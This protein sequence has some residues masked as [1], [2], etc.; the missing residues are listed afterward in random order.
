MVRWYVDLGSTVII[1]FFSNLETYSNRPIWWHY[2]CITVPHKL[3][4]PNSAF[5]LI[6]GGSNNN[7]YEDKY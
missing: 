5:M 1:D 6:D 3:T 2:L 4:R 7:A